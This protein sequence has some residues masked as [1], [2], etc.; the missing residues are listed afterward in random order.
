M[1]QRTEGKKNILGFRWPGN[2]SD[3]GQRADE[4]SYCVRSSMAMPSREGVEY[5]GRPRR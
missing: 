2:E 4:T 1:L 3:T 5:N